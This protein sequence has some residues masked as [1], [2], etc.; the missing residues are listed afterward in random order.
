MQEYQEVF[1]QDCYSRGSCRPKF[2]D[3]LPHNNHRASQD[4]HALFLKSLV[5][6]LRTPEL[7]ALI[8]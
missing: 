7:L 8:Q 6:Q 2:C 1:S 5:F 3:C 4:F